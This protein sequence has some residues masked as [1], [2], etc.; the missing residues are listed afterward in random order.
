MKIISPRVPPVPRK[1]LRMYSS[2]AEAAGGAVT[3][4]GAVVVQAT[5]RS[6]ILGPAIFCS[7][8]CRWNCRYHGSGCCAGYAPVFHS[9]PCHH[10][11]Q[12][13]A[14]TAGPPFALLPLSS[15]FCC[16]P[17]KHFTREPNSMGM[18]HEYRCSREHR[19]GSNVHRIFRWART[20]S[21]L[22]C[23]FV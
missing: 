10:L 16:S 23:R 20:S 12:S 22:R 17:C 21:F 1:G 3:I 5:P 18:Q 14:R 6:S 2:A 13:H 4:T 11:L 19:R 7:G 9:R 8:G 15:W